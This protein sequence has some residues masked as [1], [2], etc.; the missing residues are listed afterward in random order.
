MIHRWLVTPQWVTK[1]ARG[2]RSCRRET[3][4]TSLL[5]EEQFTTLEIVGKVIHSAFAA[6]ND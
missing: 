6:A 5:S 2:V 1:T 3:R 4:R